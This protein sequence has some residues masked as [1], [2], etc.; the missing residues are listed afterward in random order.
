MELSKRKKSRK[1][2][3]RNIIILTILSIL[4]TAGFT[5]IPA[6]ISAKSGV[7]DASKIQNALVTES[8]LSM[9]DSWISDRMADVSIYSR[10]PGVRSYFSGNTDADTLEEIYNELSIIKE[11]YN[12]Y[13]DL[14]LAGT[15]GQLIVS[16]L[17]ALVGK[18]DLSDRDYYQASLRGETFISGVTISRGTGNPVF[19]ISHPVFSGEEVA[20]VVFAVVDVVSFTKQFIDPV[21]IGETGYVFIYDRQG[22]I[23]AHPDK[24]LVLNSSMEDLGWSG[25]MLNEW[26]GSGI[27]ENDGVAKYINFESDPVSGW[28]VASVTDLAEVYMPVTMLQRRLIRIILAAAVVLIAV[29]VFFSSRLVKPLRKIQAAMENISEG[30]AD[31][32]IRLDDR[33]S[34]EISVMSGFFNDFIAGLARLIAEIREISSEVAS[35]RQNLGKVAEESAAASTE[36]SANL[37][38]IHP[39]IEKLN[40]LIEQSA[41]AVTDITIIVKDF[42]KLV[43]TQSAAISQSSSAVEQMI[44]SVDSVNKSLKVK[45]VSFDNLITSVKNSGEKMVSTNSLINDIN[46]RIDEL[47]EANALI[48]AVAAQTNLLSMNAAIEAAHAG[49]AGKGFAV[50]AEEIRKLAA[51][52]GDSAGN[53]G[54]TLKDI[55]GMIGDAAESSRLSHSAFEVMEKDIRNVYDSLSEIS[56]SIVELSK[57]GNE[58]LKSIGLLTETGEQVRDGALQISDKTGLIDSSMRNVTDISSSV[59]AG[60]SEIT[61]GMQNSNESM[62]L[63]NSETERLGENIDNLDLRINRFNV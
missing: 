53:I 18:L 5:G 50:V 16:T 2:I 25:D 55:V 59:L 35:V 7:M 19:F 32:T 58:I 12:W 38:S 62:Q 29:A 34:D 41:S 60:M 48:N 37:E 33:G 63:M 49:D 23:L 44:S 28:S 11:S 6:V 42:D 51:T 22:Q 40:M 1:K 43:E 8:T 4:L 61:S 46:S 21:R 15:D 20:G 27:V 10:Y 26:S 9:I 3:Q 57:G 39:Q 17:P 24:E 56:S 14:N 13:E 54:S 36:I 52:A 30:D 45:G 31:L 47:A